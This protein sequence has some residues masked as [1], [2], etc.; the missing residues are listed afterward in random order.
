M[1]SDGTLQDEWEVMCGKVYV[2][3]NHLPKEIKNVWF[4]ADGSAGCFSSQLLNHIAQPFWKWWTVIS[5]QH[6]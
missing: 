1:V 3:L 4:Q 5:E 6:Y 2:Y